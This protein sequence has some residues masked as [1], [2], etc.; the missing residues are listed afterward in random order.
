[1]KHI[2]CLMWIA[3]SFATTSCGQKA[4]VNE[5]IKID[6]NTPL[7][8]VG[9]FASNNKNM[10]QQQLLD[11]WKNKELFVMKDCHA[12]ATQFF[13]C[14]GGSVVQQIDSFI[15]IS[16]Y[17]LLICQ[18]HQLT[19]RLPAL[20]IDGI[21][22]F[23]NS[24]RYPFYVSG[25]LAP[26]DSLAFTWLTLTGVTALSRG[27]GMVAD[28]K[29]IDF[30]IAGIKD[31][32]AQSDYV[33]ISNEVSF[34]PDCEYVPK[35]MQFCTKCRDFEVFKKLGVDIVELTGNHNRDYGKQPFIDTYNWYLENGFMTFGGG[36]NPAE[37]AKPLVIEIC[38][39]FKLAFVGFNEFC[40]CGECADEEGEPGANRWNKAAAKEAIDSLR[41]AGVDF[42]IVSVQFGELDSYTPGASQKSIA[43]YL[44]DS[45]A[46]LVYGSQAHQIQ[47]FEFY[48]GKPI[49]YG[50]GNFLFDQIHRL[51]VRQSCL[52]HL[53]F[54]KGKLIQLRPVFTMMGL[55][56]QLRLA[57]EE[58]ENAIRKEVIKKEMMN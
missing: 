53:I 27:T 58:E 44:I 28:Q 3:L 56:R 30:L 8:V 7:F 32:L 42:I 46:D 17:R 37:A 21:D 52:V 12:A 38:G 23:R 14:E 4:A 31:E 40:P 11:L 20:A 50:M 33:H 55:D 2:F 10:S 29:G 15:P 25:D 57:T 19:P 35:T 26:I 6:V 36:R 48:Q 39:Q 43:H 41:A 49:M 51:G 1:M 13:Q 5:S 22:Y 16:H 34:T 24:E 18:L 9:G 45:G 54:Y 47:Q